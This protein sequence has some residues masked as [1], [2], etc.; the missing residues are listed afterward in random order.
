MG[1]TGRVGVAD[2]QLAGRTAQHSRQRTYTVRGIFAQ[3]IGTCAAARQ[4]G[5]IAKDWSLVREVSGLR[6][7]S[8]WSLNYILKYGVISHAIDSDWSE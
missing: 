4:T 6:R 5:D 3:Y 7:V 1:H 2:S 8:V